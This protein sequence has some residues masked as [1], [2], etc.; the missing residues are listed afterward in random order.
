MS[1]RSG[2][3]AH[4]TTRPWMLTWVYQSSSDRTEIDT[5]GSLCMYSTRLRALSMFTSTRPF[6]QR[7]QVGTDTGWPSGRIEVTTLG[8]GLASRAWRSSGSGGWGT[9][10]LLGDRERVGRDPTTAPRTPAGC[11]P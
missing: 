2:S 4:S 5:R 9:G 10:E 6:S 3:S 8:F 1:V 11:G 7:Y